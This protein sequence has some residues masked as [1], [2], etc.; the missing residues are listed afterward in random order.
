[1]SPVIDLV[2]SLGLLALGLRGWKRGFR[3]EAVSLAMLLVAV[4]L[5]GR[6]SGAV[7]TVL[8][9]MSGITPGA[10][11]FA[12]GIGVLLFLWALI[13]AASRILHLAMR[14]VP[15]AATLDRVAGAS[16]GVFVGL[17]LA[18]MVFSLLAVVPVSAE[19]TDQIEE[20]R[21][22]GALVDPQG[23]PQ[24]VFG[25]VAGDRVVARVIAL[26]RIVGDRNVI[27]ASGT[28][29][30]IP[31]AKAS[32]LQTDRLEAKNL[33]ERVNRTRADAGQGALTWSDGLAT[34]AET[35]GNEMYTSGRLAHG[36]PAHRSGEG[37]DLSARLRS[38]GIPHVSATQ[39]I[40]IGSSGA[41]LHRAFEDEALAR[42]DM[43]DPS[44]R[45]VGISAIRGPLG[46]LVVEVLAG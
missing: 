45:R 42:N 3:R 4:F 29:V 24:Q 21:V 14:I 16:L 40:G 6:L 10:A 13:F 39:L 25:I 18:T 38:A 26:R 32:Q 41:D 34:V 9:A 31:P 19:V 27:V 30:P 22:A 43:V 46:L 20:S 37:S 1:M 8:A 36:R 23:V 7:G 2:L 11:R 44:L 35:A 12:G 17:L 33:L 15:G 28:V 5:A